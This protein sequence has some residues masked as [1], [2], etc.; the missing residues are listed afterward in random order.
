MLNNKGRRREGKVRVGRSCGIAWK[1][2][3][4]LR[5]RGGRSGTGE[6]AC[7][8]RGYVRGES[9]EDCSAEALYWLEW[10]QERSIKEAMDETKGCVFWVEKG[11]GGSRPFGRASRGGG[12]AIGSRNL[13]WSVRN[14]IWICFRRIQWVKEWGA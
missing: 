4:S 8:K 11:G 9:E 10:S 3:R 14:M 12:M 7:E 6:M 2:E 1:T 5:E 13:A